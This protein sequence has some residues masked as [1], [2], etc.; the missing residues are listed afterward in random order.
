MISSRYHTRQTAGISPA[1][2][3]LSLHI[4]SHHS[5]AKKLDVTVE[6]LRFEH[7]YG[8]L[9]VSSKRSESDQNIGTVSYDTM[10]VSHPGRRLYFVAPITVEKTMMI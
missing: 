8:N 10:R 5:K 1:E 4:T 6:R 7:S 2:F 9:S 3:S